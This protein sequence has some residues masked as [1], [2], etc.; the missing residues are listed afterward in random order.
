[1]HD[2][3][4][5]SRVPG[6]DDTGPEGAFNVDA[7]AQKG[8]SYVQSNAW[9]KGKLLERYEKRNLWIEIWVTMAFLF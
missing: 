4:K 7:Q 2:N 8:A 5:A 9:Y 1:M 3:N 6:I